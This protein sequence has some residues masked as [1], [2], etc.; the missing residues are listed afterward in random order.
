MGN[1]TLVTVYRENST[2][3]PGRK[4]YGGHSNIGIRYGT[5]DILVVHPGNR[6]VDSTLTNPPHHVDW[7]LT[8][9]PLDERGGVKRAYGGCRELV[10]YWYTILEGSHISYMLLR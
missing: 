7:N 2:C 8:P 5:V 9:Q 4:W 1:S 6:T 10:S 3:V